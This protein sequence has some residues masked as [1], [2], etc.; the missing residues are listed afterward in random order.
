MFNTGLVYFLSNEQTDFYC[1]IIIIIRHF[2]SKY[3][4]RCPDF[5]WSISVFAGSWFVFVW[6]CAIM[7]SGGKEAAEQASCSLYQA[8]GTG[9]RGGFWGRAGRGVVMEGMQKRKTLKGEWGRGG[10]GTLSAF[11]LTSLLLQVSCRV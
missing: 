5:Q 8:D 1:I 10:H 7:G 2:W 9:G 6:P 4:F 11:H 3:V